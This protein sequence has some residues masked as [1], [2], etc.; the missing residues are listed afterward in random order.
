ME[1]KELARLR[2]PVEKYSQLP[3][4]VLY[5]PKKRWLY[6][7][8]LVTSHGPISPKQYQEWEAMLAA[9][10]AARK[11]VSAF[12][13]LRE[14]GRYIRDIAWNTEVWIAEIPDH[15]IHYN[16]DK[17]IGPRQPPKLMRKA[18]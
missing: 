15:L 3:D 11:Y 4:L 7:I 8:Q 18:K 1:S 13:N 12:P 10:F 2:F 9:G 14:Y 17:F 6:L 16:G 5:W